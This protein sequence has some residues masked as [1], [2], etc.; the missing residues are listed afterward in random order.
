MAN[1]IASVRLLQTRFLVRQGEQLVQVLHAQ[2]DNSGALLSGSIRAEM[3]GVAFDAPLPEIRHGLGRYQLTVPEVCEPTPA[4]FT[5]TADGDEYHF[6]TIL[7]RVRHWKVYLVHFS[8]HDLGYTDLP[9]VCIG[10]HVEYLDRI[11]DYCHQ[12]DHYPDEARFRWTCDTTWALKHYLAKRSPEAIHRL[13]DLVR[14]GRIEVTALFAAPNSALLTHEELIRLTYL[15]HRLAREHS[16]RITSAMT[17]DIP[18]NPWGLPQVLAKSG[19]RY[20]ST[21]VNQNYSQHGVPRARAPRVSRPFYWGSP[22]GSEILVWNADSRW[23]YSEG[24]RLGLTEGYSQAYARLPGYLTSLEADGYPFDAISLRT[25][26]KTSDNAPP[27]LFLPRIVREWNERWAYPRL[28]LA[29]SSQFFR[30]MEE[31]FGGQFPH[32]SGDWTDWWIDGPGSSALETGVNRI[33]HERLATAEKLAALG[34]L[35]DG[36]VG[37]PRAAIEQAYDDMMLYDEHTWGMWD[38]LLHPFNATT[39]EHWRYKAAFATNAARATEALLGRGLEG[40]GRRI[41]TGDAPSVV[42]FNPLAWTRSDVVQVELP[43]VAGTDQQGIHLV[44]DDGESVPCEASARPEEPGKALVSLVAKDV[45]SLGYRSY[46]L[47]RAGSAASSPCE[48]HVDGHTIENRYYRV[49]LDPSTGA[50]ASICDKELGVE[51]VDGASP[52]GLNELVYDSGEPPIHGRFTPEG[53]DILPGSCGAV[54]GSLISV[55]KCLVSCSLRITDMPRREAATKLILPWIRQEV[56]LYRDLKRIDLVNRLYKEE[57]L[58]KEGVYYAF[59]CRVPGGRFRLEVAGAVM[60]P[61]VEQLPDSCHD[62]HATGYWLDVSNDEYGVTWSSREVPVVSI[63]DINTGKWQ[64]SLETRSGSFFAYAMNNYWDTNFRE[65]QGGDVT[66]RFSLTSHGRDW[67]DAQA[68]RFGWGY[69]TDLQA[70]VLPAGQ[71]GS[72]PG[73]SH[74]FLRVEPGNVMV[75]TCKGAEDGD[76]LIVRL[77]ELEGKGTEAVLEVSGLDVISA[78]RTSMVEEDG[79]ELPVAGNRISVGVPAYGIETVRVRAVHR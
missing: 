67:G 64:T 9:E 43:G 49:A 45:P 16:F 22:D 24:R 63:G 55:A 19:V 1:H 57:T 33:T 47:V 41:T 29:T 6:E 15:A 66:F 26:F 75:F 31:A 79:E 27:C 25:T 70:V 60:T 42:V 56:I 61:G 72:L 21:A 32:Y 77:I 10:Q 36:T 18:G 73:S 65:R 13:L 53:A 8:H 5:L 39:G 35:L 40:L 2:V 17:T 69:C 3:P 28:I 11:I 71:R 14:D 23:H 12:T 38:T 4:R 68:A 78:R 59:P 50:V 44:S 52:Y 37:Y 34:S 51:L 7:D 20:L 76:G 30:Y 48:V 74:S 46:R 54:A 58:E 62:W